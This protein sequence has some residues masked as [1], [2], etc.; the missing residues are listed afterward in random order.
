MK[1]MKASE[2]IEV[3]EQRIAEFGDLEISVNTQEGG[4]YSLYGKD[5]VGV[6]T[7][8]NTKTGEKHNTIEIG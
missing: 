1:A 6:T 3:L 4:T 2:L 7:W 5:D 8:T